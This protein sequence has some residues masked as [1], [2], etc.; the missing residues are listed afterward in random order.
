[1]SLFAGIT[2]FLTAG[3]MGLWRVRSLG[4][5]SSSQSLRERIM[6]EQAKFNTCSHCYQDF[7]YEKVL[8]E[9]DW[10]AE[11]GKAYQSHRKQDIKDSS[12]P[13]LQGTNTNNHSAV[14][15]CKYCGHT[16]V[17]HDA[18]YSREN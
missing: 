13:P 14:Y 17:V 9:V 12:Y 1:M 2:L 10:R 16:K 8:R 15:K 3:G 18:V 4:S 6:L 7:A 11:T 5:D